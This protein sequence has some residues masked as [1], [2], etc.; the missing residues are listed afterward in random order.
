[1][2]VY[3][4]GVAE[5]EMETQEAIVAVLVAQIETGYP[6]NL[7]HIEDAPPLVGVV[8]QSNLL[9]RPTIAVVGARNAL[10]NGRRFAERLCH[11]PGKG[12]LRGGLG[13]GPRHRCK[14]PYWSPGDGH[15]RHGCRRDVV[16]PKGNERLHGE[17][18]KRGVILSKIEPGTTPQVRY[19]PRR[20]RL[21]SG[22]AL[23]VV[24]VEASLHSGSLITARLALEQG[25]E[26]FALPGLPFD[27]RARGNNDLLRPGGDN[28]GI[29]RI[30]V[31]CP[32]RRTLH[33]AR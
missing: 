12:R 25:R 32:W 15:G 5:R 1:M 31:E 11:Q 3:P 16:Y 22:T 9:A 33:A 28:D 26:V 6:P 20:N 2:T 19:F 23:C 29:D 10:L 8:G 13:V 24:V 14:C 7:V 30:R 4:L 27:P 21:I 17:I 18:A